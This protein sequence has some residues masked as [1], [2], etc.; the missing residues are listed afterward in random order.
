LQKA[1]QLVPFG[2]DIHLESMGL[3][4]YFLTEKLSAKDRAAFTK[5]IG[6]S[7]REV[8]LWQKLEAKAKKLE[9]DLKS[10]KL[11][12]ASKVYQ[13]LSAAPGDQ[14]LF[15]LAHSSERIVTDRIKNYLGKY[16][17]TAQEVTDRDVLATGVKAGTPKF[18]KAREELILT[19]LDARPKKIPPPEEVPAASGPGHAPGGHGPGGHGPGRPAAGPA[20]ARKSM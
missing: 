19:R 14:I 7:R 4:L 17:P 5:N 18:Q 8:D 1:R 16:L 9:K 3:F 2:I 12:K 20:L 10:A 15:L 6:L 13:V 11:Q